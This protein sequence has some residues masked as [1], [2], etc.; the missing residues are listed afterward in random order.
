MHGLA[1]NSLSAGMTLNSDGFWK[2]VLF[3]TVLTALGALIAMKPTEADAG[4]LLII[5]TENVG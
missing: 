1:I 2:T 5:R 4:K 3:R